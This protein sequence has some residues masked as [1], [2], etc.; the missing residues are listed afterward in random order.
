MKKIIHYCWFGNNPLP[1]SAKKCINS[2][3]K[4]FPD[5]E[6]K[7]W[8]ESNYDVNKIP[9]TQQAYAAEK[10]A[11]VSDF[12]RF[13]ILY[14]EGG[15]YF[16]TDVEVIRSFDDI[17]E[18][19][20]FMGCEI[21]ANEKEGI[22]V[23]PGLGIGVNPG[24]RI[25]KALIEYYENMSFLNQDGSLNTTTVVFHTTEVLKK[26]GLKEIEGIQCIE[27]IY[28]YPKDYF[29]PYD[30]RNGILSKTVNT[31]SIH[32]NSMTW[33]SKRQIMI[34]KVTRIFHKYFGN[35][36]FEFLKRR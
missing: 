3:R 27:G 15:I 9:Y 34:S 18:R 1:A 25:Y 29:C 22:G 35:E 13:D 21:D 17:L 30:Y 2:W 14:H 33:A 11:F 26:Y 6:I 4:Y 10:Y 5:Y 24:L 32:W 28:I 8:N 16:D 20:A 12:A 19:G 31:H 7:E 23:N 36:C